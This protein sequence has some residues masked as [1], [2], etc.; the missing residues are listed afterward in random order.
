MDNH[1]GATILIRFFKAE[2]ARDL[3]KQIL[4]FSRQSDDHTESNESQPKLSGSAQTPQGITA[5]TIEINQENQSAQHV[6]AD[7]TQIHQ[8]L[9]N[10]CTNAA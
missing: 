5:S 10:L 2:T 8:I 3:V 6:L 4:A 1:I 9:M 7:P